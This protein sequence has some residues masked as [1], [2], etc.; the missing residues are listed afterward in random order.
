MVVHLEEQLRK[1]HRGHFSRALKAT[2]DLNAK[3]F[4]SVGSKKGLFKQSPDLI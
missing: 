1:L 3:P 4:L 2:E